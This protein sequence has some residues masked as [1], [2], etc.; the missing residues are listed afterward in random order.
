MQLTE[1]MEGVVDRL[2]SWPALDRVAQPVA[3]AVGGAVGNG[4]VKDALSG[5]WIG[6]P[7]HPLLTDIPIGCWTS[8]F[9]LDIVGD[10]R[11]EPA[12][13]LLIGLGTLSAL[14]TAAAGL[15]DWSDT[16]GDDQRLGVAHAA[17]NVVAVV[18]YGLSWL[19][20]RQGDRSRGVALSLLGATAVT[21][22][23]YLGGHLGW[24]RGVNVYRHA[25]T[26]GS[27][28]WVVVGDDAA[29][30]EGSPM[31]VKAGDEDVMVVRHGGRVLA[32]ANTCGHAG[33]PLNEGPIDDEG[34]VT[35][36]W[37]QS[38]FALDGGR[39]IHG[40]ATGPQP[41]YEVRIADGQ[42]SVRRAG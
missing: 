24:R 11:T 29:L 37:H 13:D 6:H 9:V 34:C 41:A 19:R 5:T 21:A 15:S 22:G 17:G 33:G 3:K 23:A 26:H 31:V 35:C 10:E 39:V 20:R 25:W 36:P 32:I 8:A 12:A 27:H 38:V 7:L 1:R 14:P 16:Y 28:D 18:C 30:A 4:V 42:V 40:P 2:A